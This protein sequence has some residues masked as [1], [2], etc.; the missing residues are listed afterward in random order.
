MNDARVTAAKAGE[1]FFQST[2]C[3]ACGKL[4]RYVSTGKCVACVQGRSMAHYTK[5]MQEL[6]SA[7]AEAEA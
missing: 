3:K 6:R 7:R 5:T 2:P 4:P 1:M